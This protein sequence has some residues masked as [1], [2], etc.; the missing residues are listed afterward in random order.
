MER[1]S[2]ERL[3]ELGWTLCRNTLPPR[4][5]RVQILRTS[6]LIQAAA[7]KP[8]PGCECSWHRGRG[9]WMSGV[10]IRAWRPLPA[11]PE[12]KP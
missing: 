11:A 5:V 10:S 1:V 4:G 6:G 7:Y 2:D 9:D 8:S 3:A 12:V